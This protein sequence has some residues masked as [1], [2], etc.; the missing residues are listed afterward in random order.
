M[1]DLIPNLSFPTEGTGLHCVAEL[2]LINFGLI[3]YFPFFTVLT[4]DMEVMGVAD[5]NFPP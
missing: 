4:M 1:K 3:T 5:G 2:I